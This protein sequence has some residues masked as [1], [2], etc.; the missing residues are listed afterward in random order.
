MPTE[1]DC[2]DDD[3]LIADGGAAPAEAA[4]PIELS[5]DI[6]VAKPSEGSRLDQFIA[7]A[8]PGYSRSL[9]QRAIEA[10]HALINDRQVKA[11][12]RIR[13]GDQLRMAPL[14][15]P[16]PEATPEN[17]PLDILYEDEY[18]AVVN[19][20][21]RMVVHPARGNWSGT[22]V[23][24][25]RFHFSQLSG[26]NGDYRPGIVHRLDRD[27]SGVI[28]IAKEER[29]HRELSIAFESRTVFKEYLCICHGILDR[30]SD[31]IEKPIGRHPSVRE[32]MAIFSAASEAKRIREAVTYYE[33]VER[34][35]G[36]TYC[37]AHPKTGRTHQIRVHLASVGC[38]ILADDLYL[39]QREFRLQ[40]INPKS[41]TDEV[42]LDRQALHAH[43]LKIEHPRLKKWVE[44]VA[45]PPPEF[46]QTLEM[47][48]QHRPYRGGRR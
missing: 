2:L 46:V 30:D 38:P 37:N 36:F 20:P 29:T 17:I 28:L 33:V 35:D 48:R 11:S 45:P 21:P 7:S 19:K 18:L 34:F 32:K 27:T 40:Q 8:F 16:H 3:E 25:L 15:P 24:A 31:Y 44:F 5:V 47:L 13:A 1:T 14:E 41:V 42:L 39:G 26:V 43:R 12:Y 22:L 4:P 9:I 23:N 6:A 10:G